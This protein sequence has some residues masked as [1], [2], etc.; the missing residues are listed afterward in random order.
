MLQNYPMKIM[1]T[2]NN[3]IDNSIGEMVRNGETSIAKTEVCCVMHNRRGLVLGLLIMGAL[4]GLIVWKLIE[5]LVRHIR[6]VW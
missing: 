2:L 5:F 4:L 3:V 1:D 6:W